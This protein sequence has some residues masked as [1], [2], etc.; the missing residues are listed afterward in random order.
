MSTCGIVLEP[1]LVL[2]L[3]Q[4]KHGS[5]LCCCI[6]RKFP[7]LVLVTSSNEFSAYEFLQESF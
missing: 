2:T 5:M 4:A 1:E 7:V 6:L 3:Y